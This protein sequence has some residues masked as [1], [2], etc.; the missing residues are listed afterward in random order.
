M[1]SYLASSA[2]DMLLALS[3]KLYQQ[4]SEYMQA[5][6][7]TFI[8]YKEICWLYMPTH[9]G[10]TCHEKGYIKK[11]NTHYSYLGSLT[12]CMARTPLR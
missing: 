7:F 5:I 8:Y 12:N 4:P 3:Q 1:P 9:L 6:C 11:N 2:A 10:G